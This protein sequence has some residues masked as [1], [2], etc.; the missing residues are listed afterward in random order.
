VRRIVAIALALAACGACGK[1]G[2]GRSEGAPPVDPDA[3]VASCR[4]GLARAQHEPSWRRGRTIVDACRPCGVSWDPVL[5]DPVPAPSVVIAVVD[6]C[7]LDCPTPARSAFFAAISALEMSQPP[8][9]AW[10]AFGKACP[11]V[12][13]TPG[14]DGRYASGAWFALH[15]IARRLAAAHVAVPADL[16]IALPLWSQG[17]NGLLLPEARPPLVDVV[18]SP[19]LTA[20]AND[21]FLIAHPPRARFGPDGLIDL[22]PD[23]PGE[24]ID[25]DASPTTLAV[26]TLMPVTRLRALLAATSTRSLAVAPPRAEI[27]FGGE[28]GGTI[29]PSPPPAGWPPAS[30]VVAD[31]MKALP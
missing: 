13:G 5:A 9:A 2:S 31:A 12:L 19:I 1:R 11:A 21:Q 3:W 17:G 10:L 30:G 8:S 16:T 25:H 26:P 6:A 14:A 7:K 24:K 18:E 28:V 22:G 4:D 23:W 29:V 15:Q 20:T 27:L